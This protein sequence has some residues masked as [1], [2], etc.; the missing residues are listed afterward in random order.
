M[1]SRVRQTRIF[2][3]NSDGRP[4]E[5]PHRAGWSPVLSNL[6]FRALS[7]RSIRKTTL[8]FFF[9][10]STNATTG[11]E[12]PQDVV[13]PLSHNPL[14]KERHISEIRDF[15]HSEPSHQNCNTLKDTSAFVM[16]YAR[17]KEYLFVAKEPG[18]NQHHVV[19]IATAVQDHRDDHFY[20]IV[21]IWYILNTNQWVS[22]MSLAAG[23]LH[24]VKSSLCQGQIC[25]VPL[26][27]LVPFSHCFQC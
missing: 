19:Q 1:Q 2:T 15:S 21:R 22:C 25:L 7:L 20:K 6:L 12:Q 18:E 27:Q 4:K 24:E 8:T 13:Q 23:A 16:Q 5:D 10:G 11:L 9:P 17:R 26:D 14:C 3:I